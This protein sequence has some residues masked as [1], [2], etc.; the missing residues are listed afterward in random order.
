MDLFERLR[1]TRIL[2]IDDDKWIRDSLTMYFEG[3]GCIIT[4]CETAE[5]G[6]ENLN[7]GSYGVIIA[8]YLLPGMDGIEFFKRI[9][10]SHRDVLKVLITAYGSE[11]VFSDA[12]GVGVDTVI[13]K[14]FTAE[15]VKRSLDRLTKAGMPGAERTF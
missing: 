1:K 6:L 4:A 2:L 14:P 9:R 11:K 10:E 15:T 12:G 3:E 8:D 13:E 5:E 7:H